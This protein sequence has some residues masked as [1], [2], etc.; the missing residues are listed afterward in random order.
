MHP[1]WWGGIRIAIKTDGTQLAVGTAKNATYVYDVTYGDTVSIA[2]VKKI[3]ARQPVTSLAYTPTGDMLA[4]GDKGHM[5]EVHTVGDWTCKIKSKWCFHASYVSCMEW[6]TDGAFLV[7]GGVDDCIFIWDIANPM[8]RKQI[9][10]AHGG[11]VTGVTWMDDKTV[12]SC[13]QDGTLCQWSASR[14]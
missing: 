9:R 14:E 5:I 7:S 12:L 2:E 13:G 11:G 1:C 6:S 4:I 3:D 10:F 8:K